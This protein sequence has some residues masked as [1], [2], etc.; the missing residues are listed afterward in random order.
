M[1]K[2]E[3]HSLLSNPA[4]AL[5]DTMQLAFN[6][7]ALA[8]NHNNKTVYL[9]NNNQASILLKDDMFELKQDEIKEKN[10]QSALLMQ[11]K[12]I[13]QTLHPE[14][15]N[16]E[17]LNLVKYSFL[18]KTMMPVTSYLVVETESPESHIEK[19]AGT[20]SIGQQILGP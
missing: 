20:G 3:P 1:G 14:T 9:P 4:T 6:K 2:L 19:E 5:P 15:A 18:S 7:T 13:S 12:W 10:W 16:K 11:G 8:Y 17:W